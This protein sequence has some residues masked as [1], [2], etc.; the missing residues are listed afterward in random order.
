MDRYEIHNVSLDRN[1]YICFEDFEFSFSNFRLKEETM[2]NIH[3]RNVAE[4]A[5]NSILYVGVWYLLCQYKNF[6]LAFV[7]FRSFESI[8]FPLNLESSWQPRYTT[9]SCCFMESP[10]KDMLLSLKLLVFEKR[11]DYFHR[12]Q[13]KLTAYCLWTIGIVMKTLYLK[14]F[15][16]CNI[17]I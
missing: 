3:N 6:S 12:F 4:I 8:T 5:H 9:V 13:N 1:K 17:L 16:F 14:H 7:F 11:M 10:T 15:Q 2:R